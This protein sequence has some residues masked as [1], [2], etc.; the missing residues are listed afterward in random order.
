MPALVIHPG[1]H[2]PVHS[3]LICAHDR[4][5]PLRSDRSRGIGRINFPRLAG[6]E[7]GPGGRA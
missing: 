2:L 1:G 4:G 6:P 5:F 3:L 7:P